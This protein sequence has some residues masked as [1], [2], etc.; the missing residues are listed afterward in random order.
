MPY[1]G[2]ENLLRSICPNDPQD[3]SPGPG[4]FWAAVMAPFLANQV[5]CLDWLRNIKLC[6]GLFA[7]FK[8]SDDQ[9]QR[10]S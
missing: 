6:I 1:H 4:A 7:A 3:L 9:A 8:G 5:S 2:T 10:L